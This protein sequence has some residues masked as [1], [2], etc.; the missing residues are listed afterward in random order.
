MDVRVGAI[1]R[2][3]GEARITAAG[4]YLQLVEQTPGS[5]QIHLR[6]GSC[7]RELALSSPI[8]LSTIR[9]ALTDLL[10][11]PGFHLAALGIA[12][13]KIVLC[14]YKALGH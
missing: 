2:A 14:F 8:I 9:Q 1:A 5:F 11:T 10:N 13:R 7:A 4:V 3:V 12:S 6:P